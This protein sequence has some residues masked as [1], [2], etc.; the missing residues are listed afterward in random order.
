MKFCNG[1]P[2]VTCLFCISDVLPTR[3]DRSSGNVVELKRK[4]LLFLKHD[5]GVYSNVEPKRL[6]VRCDCAKVYHQMHCRALR[7]ILNTWIS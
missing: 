4:L 3:R 2:E 6:R 5:L 7:G 1:Q